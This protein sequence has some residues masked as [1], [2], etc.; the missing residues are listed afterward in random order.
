MAF[1]QLGLALRL[2]A[3]A[4]IRRPR[5]LAALISATLLLVPIA[6]LSQREQPDVEATLTA[7]TPGRHAYRQLTSDADFAA[8]T[9]TGTR[10]SNGSLLLGATS[11]TRSWAGRT[12]QV[13]Q[14]QSPWIAPGFTFRE[15]IASW[16]AETP[17]GSWIQV[18][19]QVRGTDG[20]ASGLKDLGKW[21]ERD[22]LLKRVSGPAQTDALATV[23][24]DT[25]KARPGVRWD[26]YRFLVRL[27]RTPGGQGPILR[28]VGAVASLPPIGSPAT[29]RPLQRTAITLPVPRYSQM[30]HRGENPEYG[31]GGEAWCSP[32][33]MAMILGYYG[34][35]PKASEYPWTKAPQGFVNFLARAAY[36]YSYE[37]AGNWPFNTA[38]GADRVGDGFVTRLPSLASAERL[39]RAGIPL[40]L[41]IRF[42]TGELTGA[43]LRSTNGHLVVLVGFTATG[44]PIVNDP[45]APTSATVR[46]TYDRAQF[47]RAWQQGSSGTTYL[48]RDAARPLPTRSSSISPW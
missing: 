3:A 36:D 43:P 13:G 34:R 22:G 25:L 42:R 39:I 41:S 5:V 6:V 24:T 31:G 28:A 46:R 30:I 37:G 27:M 33:S 47:E 38:I 14:W 15:L 35:L 19:V 23:A 26:R 20:K 9:F 40:A 8:G 29:S 32:T 17:G 18:L 12:Y 4:L 21:A 10:R 1:T 11:T 44:R 48:I 16:K 2:R 7:G 45:A